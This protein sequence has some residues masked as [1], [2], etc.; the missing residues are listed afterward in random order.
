VISVR[1]ISVWLLLPVIV[2]ACA[3]GAA[4]QVAIGPHVGYVYPAGAQQGTLLHVIVAGQQ[5]RPVTDVYISGAGVHATVIRSVP[6]MRKFERD[7]FP[8]VR[9][10]L[11]AVREDP[12]ADSA[13]IKMEA[14]PPPGP[15]AAPVAPKPDG[16]K[17]KSDAPRA[18]TT[19]AKGQSSAPADKKATP[20]AQAAPS[21]DK[22]DAPKGRKTGAAPAASNRPNAPTE[23][24]VE[25][26]SLRELECYVNIVRSADKRQANVQLADGL[27]IEI[28][29]DPAAAVGDRELRLGGPNGLS[30]PIRFQI[31]G[32]PEVCEHEAAGRAIEEAVATITPPCV[33]NGQIMPGDED[34][35][36]FQAKRGE[37]MVIDVQARRLVPYLADAVPGWFEPVVAVYDGA[38]HELAFA[39][40]YRVNPDPTLLYEVPEDGEYRL[41]IHDALY[42]G[43]E[44]FV[45]RVSIGEL[46]F[47]TQVFPLGTHVGAST[48]ATVEGWNLPRQQVQLAAGGSTPGPS[49]RA[50]RIAQ[51]KLRSNDVLY[52]VD[53]VPE[54][55]EPAAS[56]DP[57][58]P[59]L[60]TLPRIINGRIGEPG[61][62]DVYRFE[63][64]AGQEI[65]AE[66]CARRLYS[67]LDSRLSISDADGKFLAVN[68]DMDASVIPPSGLL[69]YNADSYLRVKLPATGAYS[70]NVTDAAGHGGPEYGY[71]LRLSTPRPDFEV[72]ITPSS[73]NLIAGRATVVTAYALRKDGFDGDIDIG[74]AGSPEGSGSVAL[75]GATIPRGRSSVRF[76]ITVSPQAIS[77]G[78]GPR[79]IVL[80]GRAVVGRATLTRAAVPADDMMQAFAYHHL[81]PAQEL[82]V[83]VLGARQN[84]AAASLADASPVRIPVGGTAEVRVNAAARTAIRDLELA[85]SD[86]P[87]GITLESVSDSPGG[88][89]IV[90]KADAKAAQIGLRDNL[91]VGVYRDAARGAASGTAAAAQRRARTPVGY[92]PAIPFEVVQP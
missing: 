83:A 33:I 30:N 16:S 8:E 77:P 22:S 47:I 31:S 10:R 2:A 43:R 67:R 18:G 14:K 12:R 88:V 84:V 74:A 61:E 9:K 34:Q 37:H 23:V 58:R 51:G 63:G 24:P 72:R 41:E 87:A 5:L 17:G 32:M 36:L 91:I 75:Q 44:D 62:S 52:A 59:Q 85:L 70:V 80:E 1:A 64:R 4:A 54:M 26:L 57:S 90:F 13:P 65:V 29:V 66:I 35:Y 7:Q 68:D 71:R 6:M 48:M 27:L 21:K 39:D 79:A 42:R 81:V 69:T 55:L 19:D 45:Y 49:L 89:T 78:A 53:D 28:K 73:L 50:T 76:T 40:E 60:I 92:L 38:G 56:E 82:L 15:T 25:E 46:P 11:M 20:Q 86:P 3:A